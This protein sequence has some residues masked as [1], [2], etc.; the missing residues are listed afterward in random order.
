MTI[1]DSFMEF[2]K[3]RNNTE[4]DFF[5]TTTTGSKLAQNFCKT[6]PVKRLCLEYAIQEN[7]LHG[8]WGGLPTNKRLR[9]RRSKIK[10]P[11]AII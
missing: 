1:S 7:I 10:S 4:I 5:P 2:A 8:V 6:C 11:Q 9:I 3:C